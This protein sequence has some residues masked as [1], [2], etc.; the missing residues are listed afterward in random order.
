MNRSIESPGVAAAHRGPPHNALS[1]LL[2]GHQDSQLEQVIKFLSARDGFQLAACVDPESDWHTRL[3]NQATNILL[4]QQS[5]IAPTHPFHHPP[6]AETVFNSLPQ[7]FPDLRIVVFGADMNDV[8][9]RR[10]LRLGVQGLVD[11]SSNRELL[12]AAIEE[13]HRGGYWVA[14]KTLEKLLHSAV[15][16]ERI[17]ERGFVDQ[18]AA[19]QDGLTRRESEVLER[20]LEGMSNKEIA[21]HLLLSEQGVKMHLGRLFKK[22]GVANRAQLILIAFRRVCPFNHNLVDYLRQRRGERD[23]LRH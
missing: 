19:M 6:L 3:L 8:F 15:E 10:M 5:L 14:R 9:V 11:I 2:V 18:I 4:L 7:R 12:G 21:G 13:V 22:F 1:I 20:V 23:R 16:I 17:I